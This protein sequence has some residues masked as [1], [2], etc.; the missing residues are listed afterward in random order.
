VPRGSPGRIY[1]A[2]RDQHLVV[3]ASGVL[4]FNRGPKQHHTRPAVD[5]LFVSAAQ[6]YGPRAVGVI[7]TGMATTVS[8]ASSPSASRAA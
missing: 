1:V 2:P 3:E 8:G 6:A 7:L 4:R 5:P